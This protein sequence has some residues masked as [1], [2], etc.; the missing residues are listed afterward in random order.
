VLDAAV[1]VEEGAAGA[2]H[3]G[4]ELRH[5]IGPAADIEHLRAAEVGRGG[6]ILPEPAVDFDVDEREFAAQVLAFPCSVLPGALG[7][8]LR[9]GRR[10]QAA[11]EALA[12]RGLL[13]DA[14]V[15]L[16]KYDELIGLVS[17]A[18]PLNPLYD[19]VARL[20]IVRAH[21]REVNPAMK[22]GDVAK[23]R[24]SFEAFDTNWDSIEDLIKARSE[25]N[26]VAVEKGM[27]EIERALMPEKPDP[28]KVTA[29]V[30]EVLAKYNASLAE[31]AKEAR[32]RP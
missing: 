30:N 4:L 18:A 22:A 23:A 27:I 25:D 11:F 10:F 14:Q 32:S 5:L 3:Q 1:M 28:A 8:R 2:F 9:E 24:K 16:A 31:V 20:R 6:R 19:D 13:A 17:K 15:M 26:Y 29:L 7:L 21:L 12:V